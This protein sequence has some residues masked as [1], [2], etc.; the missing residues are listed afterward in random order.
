[1]GHVTT[2]MNMPN[3]PTGADFASRRKR[4]V[5]IRL[6]AWRRLVKAADPKWDA[7]E[8]LDA[9]VAPPS[10]S[11]LP[12]GVRPE[13]IKD[14]A[15]RVEYEAAIERHRQKCET[16]TEQH[17]LR[18]PL[19]MFPRSAERYIIQA[20]TRPPYDLEELKK[21]LDGYISDEATKARIL[22]TVKGAIE[23]QPR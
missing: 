14:A 12:P 23:R 6:H 18:E 21:Y 3:A 9:Q 7:D 19:T 1:V 20:Y 17:Q 10:A 8:Q 2:L 11:G 5:E 16:Y 4:D 15:L 22:G 13:A